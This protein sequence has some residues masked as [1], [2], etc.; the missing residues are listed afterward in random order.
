MRKKKLLS[1][2]KIDKMAE[3]MKKEDPEG[4]AK[5]VAYVKS[6]MAEYCRLM[7]FKK[8]KKMD[9]VRQWIHPMMQ[10]H[11]NVEARKEK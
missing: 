8:W 11:K 5:A 3:K 1:K 6:T 7:K 4:W 2:K 9:T 10:A